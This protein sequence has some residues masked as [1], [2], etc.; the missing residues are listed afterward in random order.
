MRVVGILACGQTGAARGALDVAIARGLQRGGYC[1]RD[2]VWRPA[3]YPGGQ[4]QPHPQPEDGPP[5]ERY[6]FLRRHGTSWHDC[7][8]RL[9]L[10]ADATLIFAFGRDGGGLK[11]D[12][13]SLADSSYKPYLLVDLGYG[14]QVAQSRI[15]RWLR[16]IGLACRYRARFRRRC[17]ELTLH[18]CGP[19]ESLAPGIAEDVRLVLGGALD[20]SVLDMSKITETFDR[21]GGAK[22]GQLRHKKTGQLFFQRRG[23]GKVRRAPVPYKCHVRG[24]PNPVT[25]RE[26][27]GCEWKSGC[28]E[29]VV[30]ADVPWE[31]ELL[32]TG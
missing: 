11:L 12:T 22:A 17:S 15:E 13:L 19:K 5:A 1:P 4:G 30:V 9:V 28:V 25:H 16:Q 7:Y 32:P 6:G 14:R 21:L 31:E 29:H 24:C 10:E 18:V 8:A 20:A 26:M 27:K 3:L 2:W 23:P